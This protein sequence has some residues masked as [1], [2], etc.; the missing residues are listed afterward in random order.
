MALIVEDGS[1]V[2]NANTYA[3]IATVDAYHTAMGN[4]DWSGEDAVKE[5]A[6][7]RAMRYLESLFFV[8]LKTAYDNA[9]EWPRADAYTRDGMLIPDTT[10]PG[11]LRDA[12][13]EAALVELASPN[14]LAPTKTTNGIKKKV[15]GPLQTEY[16]A[17][18]STTPTYG[19]ISSRLTPLLR[20]SNQVVRT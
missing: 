9:L 12:L 8:G 16:F 6:I 17:G 15:V 19:T 7:R 20:Q 11:A 14:A 18:A 5:T 4:A 3:D 10:I 13:A 2:E 1:G